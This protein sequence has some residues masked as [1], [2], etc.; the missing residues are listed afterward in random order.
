MID[1]DWSKPDDINKTRRA[2]LDILTDAIYKSPAIQSVNAFA[3]KE[4]SVY[5]YQ[6]RI[7]SCSLTPLYLAL[8]LLFLKHT[9]LPSQTPFLL[10]AFSFSFPRLPNLTFVFTL[11]DLTGNTS[12]FYSLLAAQPI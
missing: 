10:A 7:L 3:K 4:A 2:Y 6:V 1:T 5:F 11:T 8:F 12:A 9:F